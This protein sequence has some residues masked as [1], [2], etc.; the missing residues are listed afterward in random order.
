MVL[1][2]NGENVNDILLVAELILEF[3]SI[4]T[5]DLLVTHRRLLLL[6]LLLISIQI[7]TSWTNAGGMC[8]LSGRRVPDFVCKCR[9]FIFTR[10]A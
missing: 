7:L 1:A 5:E 2:F 8:I 10:V 4:N 3:L 6:M 9:V